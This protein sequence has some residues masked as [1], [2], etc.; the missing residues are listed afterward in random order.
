[1]IGFKKSQWL[2]C[3]RKIQAKHKGWDYTWPWFCGYNLGLVRLRLENYVAGFECQ[4]LLHI[5]YKIKIKANLCWDEI[6]VMI[7]GS[8]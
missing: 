6:N 2:R 5:I 1:M 4:L 8:M 3:N 7:L